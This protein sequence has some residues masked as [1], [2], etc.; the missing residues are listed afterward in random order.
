MP[1][2]NTKNKNGSFIRGE[3][4]ERGDY[5]K[6]LDP[7]WSYYPT[8]IRKMEVIKGLIKSFPRNSKILDAGCGEGVLVS[9]LREK[10]YQV[11]GL[12][13]NY[14][15]KYIIPGDLIKIPFKNSMFDLV[16]MVDVIEHLPFQNQKTAIEE[17]HRVLKDK[18]TLIASIPNLAHLACRLKFLIKGELIRT[19]RINRHPGD[20]PMDEYLKLLDDVDFRIIYRRGISITIP[21]IGAKLHNLPAWASFPNLSLINIIMAR[22]GGPR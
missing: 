4:T 6:K 22:K 2:R 3:Y 16:L 10:G 21:Y 14:G 18:G 12:D 1:K 11:W 5:H 8:Y 17:V 13:F 20:R 15:A 9:E 19:S 7:S